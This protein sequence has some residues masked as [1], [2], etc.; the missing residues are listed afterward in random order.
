MV[1]DAEAA[2]PTGAWP[3]ETSFFALGINGAGINDTER[4]QM[5][6]KK[7][8]PTPR[9]VPLG[10]LE[11]A[12]MQ[13]TLKSSRAGDTLIV[14]NE[15]LVTRVEVAAPETAETIDG[16]ISAIVT[17]KT[18]LP[19]ELSSF[20]TKPALVS[21][22]NSMA[23][24][25]AVT[26][27]KGRYFVGSR[28]TVYE[29]EDAWN[30]QGRLILFSVIGAA[31]TIINATRKMLTQEPR[32]GSEPSAWTDR[33]FEFAESYLSR[34]CVCTTGGLRLTAEFGIRAGEISV[35][36]GH[37][38]T[39]LWQMIADQPHPAM[40]GGL[41]CLLNMPHE[42]ADKDK[43]Y[44]VIAEL[45]RL[46]MQ[47]NDLP[48]HFGAWC[49][50]VRDTNPAYVSFLPNALHSSDGIA[51]NMSVWAMNRAQIADAMLLNMGVS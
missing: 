22:I 13:T 10:A 36:A 42:I 26:Q 15:R 41:F 30:V 25:G 3:P 39:A 5:F 35:A 44:K 50:G 27:E 40:G 12:L 7:P 38:N 32:R 19:A 6:F 16:K 11:A 4:T 2:D 34:L 43:L 31:D 28:L 23:T 37:H 48:P 18:E 51:I 29:G 17:I 21:M 45:N 24:L 20:F 33:D 8:S 46:E 9:G 1:L 47:G 49:S 14:K